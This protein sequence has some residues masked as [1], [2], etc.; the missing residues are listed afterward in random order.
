MELRIAALAFQNE[1]LT[2][3]NRVKEL[4][5]AL[6]IKE[7]LIWHK[8]YYV[9]KE[10]LEEKFCQKC[11]DTNGKA[12]RLQE[13]DKGC[14]VCMNCKNYYFDNNYNDR[15]NHIDRSGCNPITGY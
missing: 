10:K 15:S 1:N 6:T 9:N 2:L 8:P 7:T 11:F 14:W 5:A 4:E 3:K 12:I 13:G